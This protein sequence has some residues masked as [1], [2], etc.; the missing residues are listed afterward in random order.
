MTKLK[1]TPSLEMVLDVLASGR[2]LK[3]QWQ[4]G[5][6]AFMA[7]GMVASAA[8]VFKSASDSPLLEVG[9]AM[10]T[11]AAIYAVFGLQMFLVP[12]FFM[13]ENFENFPTQGAARLYLIFFMR[14]FGLLILAFASVLWALNGNSTVFKIFALYNAIQIFQG[15]GK[16]I[17]MFDVTPKHIVPVILLPLVGFI[18]AATVM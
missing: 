5:Q 14:M 3:Q 8:A 7:L 4:Q 17:Q 11:C 6:F 9:L 10:K 18:C 1:V 16:A 15:P 2:G 12:D 13:A